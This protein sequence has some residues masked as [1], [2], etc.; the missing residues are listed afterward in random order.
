LIAVAADRY[1]RVAP[2]P[3][4][5]PA[6]PLSGGLS[7]SGS[8]PFAAPAGHQ[9][10]ATPSPKAEVKWD[11]PLDR[12]IELTARA[13]VQAEQDEVASAAGSSLIQY[14]LEKLG[15]GVEAGSF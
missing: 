5:L 4:A 3:T 8:Q 2:P 11:D 14:Q 10:R 9:A 1:L 7:A 12:E 15:R 13:A 6:G